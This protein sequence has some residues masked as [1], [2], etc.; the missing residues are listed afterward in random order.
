MSW[1]NAGM[2]WFY[3]H[4]PAGTSTD[5]RHHVSNGRAREVWG[6]L[7]RR[8]GAFQIF[9]LLW[10]S[11]DMLLMLQKTS[12]VHDML[13]KVRTHAW[14]K[15]SF[16][17]LSRNDGT[18]IT[19]SFPARPHCQAF[20]DGSGRSGWVSEFQF[21]STICSSRW[22]F[23][24]ISRGRSQSVGGVLAALCALSNFVSNYSCFVLV[25][26]DYL[27]SY[28]VIMFEW[29]NIF[30]VLFV[31]LFWTCNRCEGRSVSIQ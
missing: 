4:Q 1:R 19:G 13:N 18:P 8:V 26:I 25:G 9:H 15:A 20:V 27:L 14:P 12:Q 11:G 29:R 6:W 22:C 7:I 5:H 28:S 30:V 17:K 31:G 23:R 16:W 24:Q 10:Q 2:K 21:D 3:A